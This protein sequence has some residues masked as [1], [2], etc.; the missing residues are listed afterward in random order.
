[1]SKEITLTRRQVRGLRKGLP[2]VLT[3]IEANIAEE[4][5]ETRTETFA[6]CEEIMG[7]RIDTV[8]GLTFRCQ[9]LFWAVGFVMQHYEGPATK[10]FGD[11]VVL[12][13]ELGL[14]KAEVCPPGPAPWLN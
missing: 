5:R 1:M 12:L 3:F 6:Y 11:A 2:A 8:E 10:E 14:M 7:M 4:V 13:G 9:A